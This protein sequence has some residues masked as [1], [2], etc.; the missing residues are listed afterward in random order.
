MSQNARRFAVKK[1]RD[2][3]TDVLTPKNRSY[4]LAK[5]RESRSHASSGSNKNRFSGPFR[6]LRGPIHESDRGKICT[7]K[8]RFPGEKSIR[9][10]INRWLNSRG[11]HGRPEYLTAY[12]CPFCGGFHLSKGI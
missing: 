12:G 8:K 3:S 9:T 1:A 10:F 7:T 5:L 2:G 6:E 11:R 4:P